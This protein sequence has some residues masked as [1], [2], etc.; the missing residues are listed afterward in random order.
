MKFLNISHYN[1]MTG[2]DLT[3]LLPIEFGDMVEKYNA[4]TKREVRIISNGTNLFIHKS[5]YF[6]IS[7]IRKKFKELA[8][9]GMKYDI[10]RSHKKVTSIVMGSIPVIKW[11]PIY[12][13]KNKTDGSLK[14]V[15]HDV[16][17]D[18]ELLSYKVASDEVFLKAY[19]ISDITYKSL[20]ED[21]VTMFQLDFSKKHE[22]KSYL[23]WT[24]E[25]S[26]LASFRED[27]EVLHDILS[28]SEFEISCI[29]TKSLKEQVFTSEVLTEN[30]FVEIEGLIN[31]GQ[32]FKIDLAV[33]LLSESISQD[34][35]YWFMLLD[36]DS[37]KYSN[38]IN[39]AHNKHLKEYL[40]S[41]KSFKNINQL[42]NVLNIWDK[43][44]ELQHVHFNKLYN[45][46]FEKTV[47]TTITNMSRNFEYTE[48]DEI[49]GTYTEK[50]YLNE[51]KFYLNVEL[52][53]KYKVTDA[54]KF[55]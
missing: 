50:N 44:S 40:N 17:H 8:T 38:L 6:P 51:M 36:T 26:K 53:S 41:I 55:A 13:V 7:R 33:S 20:N 35:L 27:Y 43:M 30:K 48:Y 54:Y 10:C 2:E 49:S 37:V 47:M 11:S 52:P 42:R 3:Y 18:T 22:F 24:L 34:N 5:N 9:K 4:F 28:A 29:S 19:T 14:F 39:K 45:R 16:D 21:S 32:S 25:N 12:L 1:E 31:S 46:M 15:N 23:D